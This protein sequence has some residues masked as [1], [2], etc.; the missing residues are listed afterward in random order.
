MS[1]VS[2]VTVVAALSLLSITSACHHR[3]QRAGAG[4]ADP[5]DEAHDESL[6][7]PKGEARSATRRISGARCDRE[8]RCNNIGADQ[9]YATQ[10]AC[11]D[12]IRTEWANDLNAY[13]CPNGVV[14][15][16]LEECLAAIRAE[17]CS[18]PFDTFD[19]LTECTASQICAN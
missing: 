17:E 8:A 15:K 13:E 11:E 4:H 19:R 16:D 9:K 10:S 14:E 18:S 1:P 6:R 7:G 5:E 12:Q 2:R 3:G